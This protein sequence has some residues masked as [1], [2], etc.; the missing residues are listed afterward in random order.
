VC[1]LREWNARCSYSEFPSLSVAL[2][3]SVILL[4]LTLNT[5]FI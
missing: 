2:T 3:D 5:V 1:D 4:V